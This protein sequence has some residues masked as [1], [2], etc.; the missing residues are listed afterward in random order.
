MALIEL[1]WVNLNQLI[2]I[3]LK[4]KLTI[5]FFFASLFLSS[6][7]MFRKKTG[8][9]WIKWEWKHIPVKNDIYAFKKDTLLF[10]S[11][12]TFEF[13]FIG[14]FDKQ[15]K[16]QEI[17]PRKIRISH[18]GQYQV[19]NDTLILGYA[20]DSKKNLIGCNLYKIDKNSLYLIKE[21]SDFIYRKS[22]KES[23]KVELVKKKRD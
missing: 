23:K 1:L 11:D 3:K 6:C 20:F 17:S 13:S 21:K 22:N 7:M 5:L 16:N 15:L 18:S 8:T 12:S 10:T 4:G 2:R 14:K 19:K 9:E